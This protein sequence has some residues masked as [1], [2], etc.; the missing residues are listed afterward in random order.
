MKLKKRSYAKK[1]ETLKYK[2][3]NRTEK[4][5]KYFQVLQ[6]GREYFENQ[7]TDPSKNEPFNLLSKD[8]WKQKIDA[9]RYL[10]K[11]NY[12]EQMEGISYLLSWPV[13]GLIAIL[14]ERPAFNKEIL[15]D[16]KVNKHK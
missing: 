14:S 13:A 16:I 8:F 6:R 7:A 9:Q 3:K 11:T 1:Y 15:D 2:G 12:G 5:E 4:E 10:E